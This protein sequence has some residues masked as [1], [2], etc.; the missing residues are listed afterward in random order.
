MKLDGVPA[1]AKDVAPD[2]L[3]RELLGEAA[4][5]RSAATGAERAAPAA[6]DHR[7][8]PG[9]DQGQL[10]AGARRDA[11]AF[12]RPFPD[13][14]PDDLPARQA[15]PL[16]ADPGGDRAGVPAALTLPAIAGIY[17]GRCARFSPHPL[18]PS[19]VAARRPT[20]RDLVVFEDGRGV[21]VSGFT[22]AD[23]RGAA[24]ARETAASSAFP[25]ARSSRSSGRSTRT[26]LSRSRTRRERPRPPRSSTTCAPTRCGARPPA[27]TPTSIAAAAD[28]HALDRALLA[29]VAKVES[30]FNPYAVS[31]ARR[32]RHPPADARR[33]RSASA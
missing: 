22:F 16:P 12:G 1:F 5:T 21:R 14:E 15:D 13:R 23:G 31:P 7:R 17:P 3:V 9:G 29:A 26:T 18:S 30:N 27:A 25:R 28:R 8:L 2:R 4:H 19:C 10:P 6:G 33:P 24:H 32:L 20:R 11:A